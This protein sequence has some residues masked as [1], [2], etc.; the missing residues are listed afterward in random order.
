MFIIEVIPLSRANLI[1]SLS[2]YSTKKYLVGTFIQI[3]VRKKHLQGVVISVR[4][5]STA[6]AIIRSA[7][8]SLKKLGKQDTVTLLPE[9]L[10][11]TMTELS[12]VIPAH[13]GAI[14]FALLPADI[15]AGLRQYP[16]CSKYTNSSTSS[17][18]MLTD[19]YNNRF[20]TYKSQIRQT[21]A[22]RG[23]VLFIVPTSASVYSA[24]MQ[25]EQGIEKR[26]I[27][28]CSTHTKKQIDKSYELFSDLSTAKLII[29]TPN[30]AFLD[31]SDITTIIVEECGS[32]HYKS[33]TRPYLDARDSLKIYAKITKRTI[34][35][36]DI[37]PYTEDEISR[38][39]SE[40]ETFNEDTQR[41]TFSNIFTISRHKKNT[42]KEKN[43]DF[44]LFTPEVLESMA[45]TIQKKKKVF[46]FSARRGLSPLVLCYD[47]G[48]IF[49][50][51]ESGAPYSLIETVT[52]QDTK[53]WFISSTSGKKIRASDTCPDCGSWRL[54]EQGIGIQKVDTYLRKYFKQ[55][56][57]I[58]FDH[59]TATTHP[60]A[61]NLMKQFYEKEGT[62]LIGTSMVM[63]YITQPVSM[64]VVS[65]YEAT[66]AIPTWRADET[67]LSLLLNLRDK[68]TDA[69]YVQTRT[70]LDY[71]LKYAQKGSIDKFY[72]ESLM[73]RKTLSYPPYSIFIL[74][75][76]IGTQT[77]VSEVETYIDRQLSCTEI[78]F[79]NSPLPLKQGIARHGLIRI[80]ASNWPDQKLIEKLLYLPPAIK[81]EVNPDKII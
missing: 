9:S 4:K 56:P 49:R 2:Y 55:T 31:R 34:L 52:N 7:T 8:F 72:D 26:V 79:Y 40:Y 20:I 25:L 54:R 63:P 41:L 28:F 70:D 3:P 58:I 10:I 1:T 53:R 74:L 50:C 35:L 44:S 30:F 68:T 14:L 75:T 23:S 13:A 33:K 80:N 43:K 66:R 77:Q 21:F 36:G 46:I 62:I 48:Y 76:W 6:K 42:D 17:P 38:R 24:K 5:V 67:A 16:S 37:L 59:T 11:Q 22:H 32:N 51:P 61:K 45:R 64:T 39:N 29:S 27:T 73:M 57:I 12:K 19:T 81:I 78:Q 18:V 47:C 71:I 15:R 65:S 69:C 60:K